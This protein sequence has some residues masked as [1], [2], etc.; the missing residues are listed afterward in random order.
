MSGK[1]PCCFKE[2]SK[3]FQRSLSV[4]RV[5]QERFKGVPTMIEVCFKGILSGFQGYLKEVQRK[6]QGRCFKGAS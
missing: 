6:F 4:T 1:F 3:K 2:D 5:F